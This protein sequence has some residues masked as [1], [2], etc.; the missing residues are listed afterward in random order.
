MLLLIAAL[1]L[2]SLGLANH[3][4]WTP[5]EPRVAEIGREMALNSNWAVPTL[6]RKPFLEEPP[7][8]Y[9]AI[10]AVFEALRTS[11]DK[12][13]R[14]PSALFAFGGVLALFFLGTML[15]GPRTGFLAAG[16]MATSGEYFRV[17][18]WVIVDSA[19]TC[20]IIC[21]L[22]FFLAA[23]LSPRKG[24]RLSFYVL[25]YISCTLAFFAKGFIGV[26]VP[27]LAVLAFLI[28][29]RNLKEI[30]KM[31]LWLGIAVFLAMTLP[32]FLSLYHQGGSEYLTVFFVHN[33]LER[34][35]GGS[36]GHH[37]PFYYYLTQFPGAFLPWSVLLVPVFF[38]SF[39]KPPQLPDTSKKG[40]LFAQCWFVAGFL[41]LSAASTKRVLYL[42]P[43]FAPISLLTAWYLEATL[44]R[45]RF[46]KLEAFFIGVFGFM[47]LMVALAVI[48]LFFYAS[49]KYGF[50]VPPEQT[51]WTVLLTLAAL[52]LSLMAL[53]SR[54][55]N[56]GRFWAYS[57]ASVFSLLLLALVAV[58]PLLDRY[59][60]FVPFC[61]AVTA[62]VP[63]SAPLYGYQSDE[64]LRGVVPFYTGRFLIEIETLPAL[65]E[66]V[67]KTPT[68]FVVIR[69]KNGKVEEE[70]LS[71]GRASALARQG[72]DATRSV[73]LFT[74]GRTP[75]NAE[76]RRRRMIISAP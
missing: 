19:L 25:C 44:L 61:R 43:I 6:D 17:A 64:T 3:G 15:S 29:D 26:A 75:R 63:A 57:G 74:I 55:K 73:V 20:F 62:S 47:I 36:T 27:G 54:A 40:I 16:V 5:D 30:L 18:H 14:V 32:W 50:G 22:T 48:P 12:I 23:Y 67:R 49:R 33:H 10:G 65:E 13:V 46:G 11:S 1:P 58:M 42:M 41:L 69:D 66:A 9:A 24:R 52:L 45:A 59:K 53:R 4:L 51:T 28:F 35:A 2:F 8:Y 60:S 21:G 72:I 37:Q 31:H 34:F 76:P 7:L 38:R 71:T 39:R 68:A 70:L 56:M